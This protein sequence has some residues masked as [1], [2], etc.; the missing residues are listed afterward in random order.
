MKNKKPIQIHKAKRG[1]VYPNKKQKTKAHLWIFRKIKIRSKGNWIGDMNHKPNSNQIV[2]IQ[3][4]Q[5]NCI[6]LMLKNQSTTIKCQEK[7]IP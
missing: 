5:S 2:K 1:K 3:D 4:F 7:V 6:K